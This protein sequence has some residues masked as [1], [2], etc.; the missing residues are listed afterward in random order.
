MPASHVLQSRRLDRRTG[1]PVHTRCAPVGAHQVI[2]MEQDIWAVDLVVEQIKP[3]VW[4]RLR[5]EIQLSLKRP[6]IIRCCQAHRQSPLLRF[7]KS[8]PE[9]RTLPSTGVTRL[10]RYYGPVRLPPTPT[11]K[12]PLRPLPSARRVSADYPHH[13]SNVPC[14][15]PRWTERVRRR[16]LPHPRGLPRYLGGS[17][18]T[19]LSR[20]ARASLTLRPAGSLNRPRRPLSR[21]FDPAS[22]PT[23]PLVSYRSYRHMDFLLVGS[24][25]PPA[26]VPA[27]LSFRSGRT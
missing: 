17:A 23:E 2:G 25:P 26:S 10:Q 24:L 12:T 16:L 11:P 19:S 1:Y 7:F 13:L 6:D 18:S 14:P 22:Y 21:G 15:V 20:P 27:G 9:V 4:L 8:T 3:V 5:L